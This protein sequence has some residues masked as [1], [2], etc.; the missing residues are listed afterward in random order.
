MRSNDNILLEKAYSKVLH[1]SILKEEHSNFKIKSIPSRLKEVLGDLDSLPVQTFQDAIAN[2]NLKDGSWYIHS[3]ASGH[4]VRAFKVIGIK[5]DV[6][7]I[8][9]QDRSWN[10]KTIEKT[11]KGYKILDTPSE[12]GYRFGIKIYPTDVV[13]GPID[14][15]EKVEG[16]EKYVDFLGKR[17]MAMSSYYSSH[18]DAPMD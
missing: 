1:K 10:T 3:N 12:D 6:I 18:P 4:D 5:D 13:L 17:N 15:S 7:E 8:E 2:K 16:L 11:E 14:D 9:D